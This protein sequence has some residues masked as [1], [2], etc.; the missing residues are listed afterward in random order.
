[1]WMRPS[2]Q[3][4]FEQMYEMDW[5][6][7]SDVKSRKPIQFDKHPEEWFE[8]QEFK[9][10]RYAREK[11]LCV[12][13]LDIKPEVHVLKN[14]KNTGFLFIEIYTFSG[15][16][17]IHC[18][19]KFPAINNLL[20][21]FQL[22]LYDR[23][24]GK[25]MS[26]L[27]VSKGF[28]LRPESLKE[29]MEFSKIISESSFVPKDFKGKPGDVLVAVQMGAELGLPPM[30]AL[31]NIAVING[32]PS[33]YGDAALAVVQ[34]H[35]DCEYVEEFMDGDKAVCKVKRKG[36]PE[37]VVEFKIEDAIKAGLWKK[38]GPWTQ[39]PNRMLQMRARGFA[40]RDKFA[41]ALKGLITREEAQD[42]KVIEVGNHSVASENSFRKSQESIPTA[43]AVLEKMNT[44]PEEPIHTITPEQADYIKDLVGDDL[45]ILDKVLEL[46]SV[47]FVDDIPEKQ[48]DNMVS[49][50]LSYQEKLAEKNTQ[51]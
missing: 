8:Q 32:K 50:V 23:E 22:R 44:E 47:R 35:P 39:Y 40:L 3:I 5:W 27:I 19:K 20:T 29:A 31:Q 36:H 21:N 18:R 43:S 11:I 24:W 16:L 14:N 25:K 48:Y 49:R 2:E 15:G 46:C 7:P 28:S 38:A 30:Q 41:D 6:Y 45:Y 10:P 13:A 34:V 1:M 9:K 33:I 12:Y 37:H 26:D 4:A 17:V 42:Y 51:R